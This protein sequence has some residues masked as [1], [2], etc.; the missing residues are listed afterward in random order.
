MIGIISALV[1]VATIA[2]ILRIIARL[3]RRLRF[4]VDDYLCFTALVLLYGMF[5][6]LILCTSETNP[7][8]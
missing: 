8:K 7:S 5:I 4:G 3:K 6:E 1:G 2:V